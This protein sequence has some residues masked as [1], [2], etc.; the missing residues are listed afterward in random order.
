MAS[1]DDKQPRI[2][3]RYYKKGGGGHHGGAWKVAYA[4]FMTAMVALFIVLWILAQA[5]QVR[6]DVQNYFL[7]P[8]GFPGVSNQRNDA[9]DGGKGALEG[10]PLSLMKDKTSR[11]TAVPEEARDETLV[12]AGKKLTQEILSQKEFFP[13]AEMVEISMT[14][15]GLRI[16]LTDHREGAFF[17]SGSSEPTA[18]M[19]KAMGLI[20]GILKSVKND[21]VIEGHTDASQL[22][23]EK[24]GKR[25]NWE[26]S[27]DRANQTRRLVVE[28]GVPAERIKEV[29]AYADS[30]PLEGALPSDPR[31]RRVSFLVQSKNDKPA[32]SA[33]RFFF[34]GK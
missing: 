7:D 20:A 15:E 4:D 13:L 28:S 22:G 34:L 9:N 21:V 31:N 2:I 10:S 6:K 23:E 14:A 24:G 27:A 18:D 11:I 1:K 25:G 30:R 26:L 8:R 3:R 19:K 32:K 16:E 17:K 29:R 5:P 33:D 12:Q